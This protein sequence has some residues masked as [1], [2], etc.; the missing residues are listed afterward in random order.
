MVH[1]D[2]DNKSGMSERTVVRV[3]YEERYL[4]VGVRLLDRDPGAIA[5]GPGRRDY[6]TWAT[7]SRPP[8]TIASCSR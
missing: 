3:L 1:W 7:P 4:Y 6:R 5:R 8:S 2:P